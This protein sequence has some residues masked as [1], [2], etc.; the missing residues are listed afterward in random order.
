[1]FETFTNLGPHANFPFIAKNSWRRII[2][3]VIQPK[4]SF[5]L[6]E[7][8]VLCKPDS[9][10]HWVI[11]DIFHVPKIRLFCTCILH[12]VL[13]S[14]HYK[15]VRKIRFEISRYYCFDWQPS[16]AKSQRNRKRK[17]GK[18]QTQMISDVESV[19]LPYFLNKFI[20]NGL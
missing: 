9:R 4:T 2:M 8:S 11:L 17:N 5:H 12:R 7:T 3:R 16:S 18:F 20:M 1:M 10:F 13:E 15:F 19:M 6:I 14:V